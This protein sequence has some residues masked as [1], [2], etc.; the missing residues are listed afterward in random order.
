V[1]G[2]DPTGAGDAFLA[3]Y[4]YARAR[5]IEPVEAARAACESVSALLAARR[6]ALQQSRA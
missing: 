6:E 2:V 4:A 5:G 3:S 1:T